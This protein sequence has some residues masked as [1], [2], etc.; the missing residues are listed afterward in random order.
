AQLLDLLGASSD[1][2]VGDFS[3]TTAPRYRCCLGQV[4][5]KLGKLFGA[6]HLSAIMSLGGD[7]LGAAGDGPWP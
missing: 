7:D 5:D 2:G 6:D 4:D 3:S 1:V